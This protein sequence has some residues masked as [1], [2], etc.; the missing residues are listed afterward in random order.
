LFLEVT[1]RMLRDG[2]GD[3]DDADLRLALT[4]GDGGPTPTPVPL[5]PAT[6]TGVTALLGMASV[7]TV[8][9]WRVLR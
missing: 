5:P 8:R 2:N 9:R 1:S 3:S 7:A 6:W 4:G